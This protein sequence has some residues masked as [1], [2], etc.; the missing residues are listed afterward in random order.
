MKKTIRKGLVMLM[1]TAMMCSIMHPMAGNAG[2][3]DK[4]TMFSQEKTSKITYYTSGNFLY[5]LKGDEA[6]IWGYL[7]DGETKVELDT[8]VIPS[9]V[10]GYKVTEIGKGAFEHNRTVTENR[11]RILYS[12]YY[13]EVILPKGLKKIQFGAFWGSEMKKIKLPDGLKKIGDDAF[14][15]CEKLKEI[16]LP[17]S[18]KEIGAGAFNDCYSLKSVKIPKECNNIYFCTFIDCKNLKKVK[19]HE[20]VTYISDGAFSGCTSL[21]ELEIPD[22]VNKLGEGIIGTDEYS[23]YLKKKKTKIIMKSMDTEMSRETFSDI[24]ME[25]WLYPGADA[26]DYVVNRASVHYMKP[27]IS[28]KKLSVEKGEETPLVMYGA[29]KK[30]KWQVADPKVA[31]VIHYGGKRRNVSIKGKKKG[32]TIV[33]A[34]YKGKTYH[35]K[36]KVK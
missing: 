29:K 1:I 13:D 20:N 28:N 15:D 21:R 32:E 26:D 7:G 17:D 19:L 4:S 24:W 11:T 30:V 31:K 8:L 2:I 16:N 34:A 12:C 14:T 9:E 36:V 27:S 23:D 25:I 35:C 3:I 10:N 6:V 22:S 33:T 18:I 5:S